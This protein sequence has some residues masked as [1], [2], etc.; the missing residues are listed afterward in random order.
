MR[1]ENHFP[2]EFSNQDLD[3]GDIPCLSRGNRDWNK[4][5]HLIAA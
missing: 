2:N 1:F 3:F 5:F 4:N